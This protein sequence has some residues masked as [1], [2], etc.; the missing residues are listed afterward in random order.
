MIQR[1]WIQLAELGGIQ[2]C[3][4]NGRFHFFADR[5]ILEARNVKTNINSHFRKQYFPL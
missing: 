2:S 1:G 5:S 4:E 3:T